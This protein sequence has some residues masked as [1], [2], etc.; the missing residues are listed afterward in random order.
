MRYTFQD[1]TDFPVQRDFIQDL[2]DL[3]RISTEVIPLEKSAIKIKNENRGKIAIYE[4]RIQEIDMFE[5]DI[6]DCIE[7]RTAEVNAADILEIKARTLETSS[8]VALTKKNEK[9]EELDREN[10]LD[11]MEVQQ[12]ETRILSNLSPFF[13]DSIYGAKS[14]YYAFVE[15]KKLR[16]KQ[17]SFVDGMQYEFELYFTR[18]TL[19]VKDLHE[20]TLPV[21]SKSGIISREKKVKKLD[22]SDFYISSIEY[23]GNNL[24]AVLEDN[25][26]PEN[27]FIISA[28]EKTFL[29]LHKDYEITGYEELAAALNRDSVNIFI[30][31][32]IELFKEFV[33]SK[34]LRRIMLD[35][36]NVVDEN[37]I[38]D[39]LKLIASIY[40]QLI[41]QCIEKGYTEGEITLK[42]EEPEGI[43]TEKY[44]EKSEM[45][46]EFSTIGSEG[47]ELAK[48]LKVTET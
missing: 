1:S 37:R 47:Q 33:G 19:K 5:K 43:R 48:I 6:R 9:L 46:R 15:D 35:G 29:I 16:G 22:I 8:T 24:K 27:R 10:K 20:L 4:K 14:I 41:T 38:F 3:I 31:K 40:G 12:L 21:W 44:L 30:I 42:I 17:V 11:L 36:K 18:D 39:C 7:N 13:E 32:L 2:Q 23:E 28:D 34:R 25:K 45:L 26:D